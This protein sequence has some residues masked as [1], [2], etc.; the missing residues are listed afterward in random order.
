VRFAFASGVWAR[1]SDLRRLFRCLTL[2]AAVLARRC[3]ARTEWVCTLLCFLRSHFFP[4][5]SD[6]SDDPS[7]NASLHERVFL[8]RK[9][10]LATVVHTVG[11][12]DGNPLFS[13]TRM[14]LCGRLGRDSGLC[15][16]RSAGD[17]CRPIS[18]IVLAFPPCT[19]CLRL[20]GFGVHG[21]TKNTPVENNREFDVE[22]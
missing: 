15:G 20:C 3:H 2:G 22:R 17:L 5:N 9:E 10:H 11:A 6:Q 1:T 16:A 14:L 13:V 7:P 19:H 18:S 8:Y 12:I 4:P 21:H